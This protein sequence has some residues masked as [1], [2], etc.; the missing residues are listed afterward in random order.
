MFNAI[1]QLES[2]G[3]YRESATEAMLMVGYTS[4]EISHEDKTRW[5]SWKIDGGLGGFDLARNHSLSNTTE[6]GAGEFPLPAK[7]TARN[8]IQSSNKALSMIWSQ[9]TEEAYP[10]LSNL[11]RELERAQK[12]K[13]RANLDRNKATIDRDLAILEKDKV[14]FE[15]TLLKAERD[16]DQKL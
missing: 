3:E 6:Y 8:G 2:Q 1:L 16:Q 11:K 4:N 10:D 13:D 7:P 15:R 5:L 9:Q 14:I 12:E